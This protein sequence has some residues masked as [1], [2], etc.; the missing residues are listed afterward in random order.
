MESLPMTSAECRA[1][2]S[3]LRPKIYNY[4]RLLIQKGVALKPGQE[5][6]V[7]API[8]SVDFV[9]MVVKAAYEAGARHVT[10]GW[11]DDEIS[12]LNYENT[13]LDFFETFPAWKR[14]QLDGLAAA[15]ACFL[16]LEG[17]DPDALRGIDPTKPAAY[18]LA[19]NTACTIYRESIDFGKLP[20]CIA[21]VPTPAWSRK[22]FPDVS[23]EE[24][25][26]RL[27]STILSVARAD[28]EN[29]ASDW[30]THNAVFE[31]NLRSLN[32]KHYD[33]LHY[34]SKNG[35][36]F[37]LGLTDKHLWEGGAALTTDG[38]RFFPNMPTEEVF[39]TPDCRRAEGTVFSALP[40]SHHGSIVRNFWFRFEGGQVVDFDAEQGK[41]VLRSILET[42]D[43]ARRLGECAL[44][45]KNSPIRETGL[46]FYSTLFDENAS[47]HLALGKGFPE[48]Y[49]GGLDMS[50]DELLSCGVNNSATH[51][52]F[53]IGSDDLTITGISADGSET[54]IFVNGQWA[55]E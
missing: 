11:S 37:T 47:C 54:A 41:D 45:S 50:V 25:C 8:D 31:K 15:G 38:V 34:Q 17:S 49:E 1:A 6:F 10:L 2:S 21:G 44:I 18:S 53:M 20:W 40:L 7:S 43:G 32:T 55:W 52:D 5:L 36:D 24:A 42:D 35:T 29:P 13:P 23:Q 27:W 26:Y 3:A 12:R 14:E 30:D 48:C 16:W 39:T 22:V 51:V 28:G 9:R 46:L 33:A 19:A 4:A